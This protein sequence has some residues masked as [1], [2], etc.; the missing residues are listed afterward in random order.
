MRKV[1]GDKLPCTALPRSFHPRLHPNLLRDRLHSLV[2]IVYSFSLQSSTI[3]DLTVYTFLIG[4]GSVAGMTP[5]EKALPGE[6]RV[7]VSAIIVSAIIVSAIIVSA[8]IG[9]KI[10]IISAYLTRI[11]LLV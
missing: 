2:R 8:I 1:G 4:S 9:L 6:Y 7:S 5:D 10:P 11:F 3:I